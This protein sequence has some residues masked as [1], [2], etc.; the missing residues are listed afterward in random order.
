MRLWSFGE[1]GIFLFFLISLLFI[2]CDCAGSS[3]LCAGFLVAVSGGCSLSPC[4][5]LSLW[6]LSRCRAQSL[7]PWAS[8]AAVLTLSH[9]GTG[10]SCPM[11]CGIS[12]DQG[13]NPAPLHWQ[14]DS[15]TG[16]PG[17]SGIFLNVLKLFKRSLSSSSL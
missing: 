2:Y 9:C 4:T 6:C 14:V 1:F 11:A 7:G 8:V 15:T 3:L 12:P 10:L 16:S 5:G 17:K 13:L